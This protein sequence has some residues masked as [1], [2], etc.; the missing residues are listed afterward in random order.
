MVLFILALVST[1]LKRGAQAV[2]I[3]RY[4][5]IYSLLLI[6]GFALTYWL[7]GMKKHFDVPDYLAGR[8]NSFMTSFYTSVLAQSN[9]MPDTVPKSTVARS[10][11][12]AQVVSG[13]LWFLVLNNPLANN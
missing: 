4:A 13:W 6:F 5:A 10:L 2:W 7:M 11:F 1:V 12:M 3:N 8:E 9:A